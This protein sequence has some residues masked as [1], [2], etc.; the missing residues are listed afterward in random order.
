M[1]PIVTILM[2]V[3][4]EEAAIDLDE[5]RSQRARLDKKS[6][7]SIGAAKGL[8]RELSK[9]PNPKDA[10]YEMMS[11]GWLTNKVKW[12]EKAQATYRQNSRAANAE[13]NLML[14]GEGEHNG[15]DTDLLSFRH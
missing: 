8:V 11:R 4:D 5:Y 13:M 12:P 10:V 7:W 1:S 14:L 15:R 2:I 3:L 9:H 6:V